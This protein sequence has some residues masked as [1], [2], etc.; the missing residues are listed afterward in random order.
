MTVPT[1]ES[2]AQIQ[3]RLHK[4]IMEVSVKLID[5]CP[6]VTLQKRLSTAEISKKTFLLYFNRGNT[7]SV[8]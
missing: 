6:C 1:E 7:K 5:Y 2:S 8:R 4:Y 3:S